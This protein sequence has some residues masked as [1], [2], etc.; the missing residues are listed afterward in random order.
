MR[1]LRK[2]APIL[3][4]GLVVV[5]IPAMAGSLSVGWDPVPNAQGY[6]VY[7][8]TSPGTYTSSVQVGPVPSATIDG[9]RDCQTYYVAVKAFNSAGESAD[10]SP[11]LSG[12]PRPALGVPNPG[13]AMQGDVVTLTL[14][15]SNVMAGAVLE[16]DNPNVVVE[17]FA[18]S[19][20]GTATAVL[21]V[22]PTAAG[23]R[24]AEIGRFTLTVVNPDNVFGERSNALEVVIDPLRF[25]VN[26]SDDTTRNRLDG[27]DTVWMARAFG[28]Q[29]GNALYQPDYDLDGDGWVDGSDL[30][31]LASNLGGCWNG[32]GWS[33]A[34]CAASLR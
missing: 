5:A 2:V 4:V 6:R 32:T 33:V 8:G 9:L 15:A 10:F 20:C 23:V 21:S 26:R 19:Q 18:S 28:V 11:E 30:A 27:K 12:W 7:Y 16:V 29:E 17:S 1:Q 3:A 13:V 25:D 24:P 31:Y 14:P 34:A 22:E